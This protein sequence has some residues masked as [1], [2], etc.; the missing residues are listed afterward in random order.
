MIEISKLN[1]IELQIIV[2][3]SGVLYK[4]GNVSDLITKDGFK[5]NANLF[6]VVEG[7]IPLTMAKT[8]GL[9]VIDLAQQFYA[10]KPN[11]VVTVADRYET[12]ATAI[13]AS[14]MNIPV[15][16]TQGGEITG[17]IDENVRHACTKLSHI[18]FPATKKASKII[19]QLGEEKARIFL[20]GCPAI[21][22]AADTKHEPITNI[23]GRYF[24]VGP[25]IDTNKPYL[26]VSQHPVTTEFEESRNSIM[27]TLEAVSS[28]GMQSIWLWPNVDSGGDAISKSLREFREKNTNATIHFYRNFSAEDYINIIRQSACIVGNSSSGIREANFLGV[29][30]VN[31]GSRQNGREIGINVMNVGNEKDK[32]VRHGK[33]KP[34]YIYGNGKSGA[35]IANILSKVEIKIEKQFNIL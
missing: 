19:E 17:S 16:H 27:A 2:G 24:G 1:N 18:H 32:Q 20:T 5:I 35:K 12:L 4:Y 15:A 25:K 3:A 26:L 22:L 10:L 23:L 6:T 29:P 7:D 14:Y 28:Y 13:A 21:D 30:T 33:Y 11:I 34:E 8:T 9:G 31:I